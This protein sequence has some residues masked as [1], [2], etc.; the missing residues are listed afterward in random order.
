MTRP[1]NRIE[2]I[3]NAEPTVL[4]LVGELRSADAPY[5]DAMLKVIH[6]T[7]PREVVLDLTGAVF[8]DTCMLKSIADARKS[9]V[10]LTIQWPP[11]DPRPGHA[12]A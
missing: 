2:L 10:R 3:R 11:S 7:E 4:R 12:D 1:G 5:I 8:L 6:D 9:G